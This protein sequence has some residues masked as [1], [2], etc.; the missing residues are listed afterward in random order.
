MWPIFNSN[1]GN[2][3]TVANIQQCKYGVLMNDFDDIQKLIFYFF[4]AVFSTLTAILA[5]LNYLKTQ[6]ELNK[7]VE[8]GQY[9][10]FT[11]FF[12]GC[13]VKSEFIYCLAYAAFCN[14]LFIVSFVDG[15]KPRIQTFLR[16][17]A[18]VGF[19]FIGLGLFQIAK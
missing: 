10:A 11:V 3:E 16:I 14:A 1:N 12:V 18:V 19:L 4:L 9:S 5:I 13:G 15:C 8:V 17:W 2:P 7:T 6:G